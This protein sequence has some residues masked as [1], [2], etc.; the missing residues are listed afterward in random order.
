MR[1]SRRGTRSMTGE[2]AA[3]TPPAYAAA[4]RSPRRPPAPCARFARPDPRSHACAR[5]AE[6]SWFCVARR[7]R[8]LVLPIALQFEGGWLRFADD[9]L[10]ARDLRGGPAPPPPPARITALI[11]APA[12]T[13][14]SRA[15]AA[16][17]RGAA[18]TRA[19]RTPHARR[20]GLGPQGG[21]RS[22][23]RVG[24]RRLRRHHG[25]RQRLR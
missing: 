5:R 10:G 1:R 7:L 21:P 16:P 11:S 9:L 8:G 23:Q 24:R 17:D 14:R 22:R 18:V 13:R 20:K 3:I 2:P 12:L 19:V 4:G 6:N 25:P 15:T